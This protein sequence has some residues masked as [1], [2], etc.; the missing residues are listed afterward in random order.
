MSEEKLKEDFDELKQGDPEQEMP[1]ESNSDINETAEKKDTHPFLTELI[2]YIKTILLAFVIAFFLTQFIIINCQVPTGSM[3]D[4]IQL[5]D[6][7]IGNRLAYLFSEPERGDIVIFPYP[8]NPKKIYIKRLIGLP[9]ETIEVKDGRVYINGSEEPLDEP[10]LSEKYLAGSRDFGPYT[11]PDGCYF[12]LGDH[13]N[14][15]LDS[16][17]W[18]NTCVKREDI[19]AEALFI[20]FPFNHASWLAEEHVY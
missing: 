20:Y 7:I 9:G 19:L 18:T 13:R 12:M 14:N 3:L 5:K 8:D 10:N 6:R 4:T 15:S 16:R 17:F 2:S 1:A 11:I